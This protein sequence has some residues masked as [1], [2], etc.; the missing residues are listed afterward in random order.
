MAKNNPSSKTC[1]WYYQYYWALLLGVG[2]LA[3]A[4]F[5]GLRALDTGSLQQYTLTFLLL[6]LGFNRL[7]CAVY[8]MAKPSPKRK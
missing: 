4:Y 2:S 7:G 8:A 6:V 3:A 1:M 5:V